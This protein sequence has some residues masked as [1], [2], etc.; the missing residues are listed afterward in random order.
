[1]AEEQNKLAKIVSASGLDT[2]KQEYILEKFQDFFKIASEWETA[3][4][5]IVVSRPDQV[6]EMKMAREGRLFLKGKR[7]EIEKSRTRTES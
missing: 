7:V 4:K 2:Q 6:A 1:M 5:S 3:A